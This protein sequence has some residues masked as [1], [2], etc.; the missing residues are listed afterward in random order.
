[1]TNVAPVAASRR[2]P[3]RPQEIFA[4]L[5]DPSRHLEID[6]SGMLRRHRESTPYPSQAWETCSR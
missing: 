2:I 4:I 6:G 5:A 3:A 1:M